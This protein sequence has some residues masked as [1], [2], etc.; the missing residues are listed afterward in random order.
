MN[1][2]EIKNCEQRRNEPN[3]SGCVK[4]SLSKSNHAILIAQLGTPEAPTAKAV[5]PYLREFL[6]DPRVIEANRILWWFVLNCIVLVTR[7]KRSARLY[8][9]IWTENGS[10]LL[11]L[12]KNFT[13]KL[14]KRLGRFNTQVVY[15]MRYGKPSIKSALDQLEKSGCKSITLVPMYPQ[16][17]ATT[18]ASTYDAFFAEVLKRRWVPTVSVVPP[19]FD[20][21]EFIKAQ[22]AIINNGLRSL[23][24]PTERLVLSY[25]GIPRRYIV[26][27]DPYCCMCTATTERLLP[28]LEIEPHKVIHTYQSRFGREPW[29]EPY[30][31]QTIEKLAREGIK[32]IAVA[33]PGFTT[34]CLET[35]DEIGNEGKHQ[36][37]EAGGEELQLIPCLNDSDVWVEA[38]ERILIQDG[39]VKSNDL[40]EK[41]TSVA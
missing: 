40:P 16:Y 9:R 28:L 27:G 11:L 35:L 37:I 21:P 29:L 30:T 2:I 36:F 41:L 39:F 13:A 34:D 12:T 23:S 6:S 10:P 19:Y 8:K 1:I 24:K 38:L 20:H 3:W 31:D 32:S 26:A 25:H 4:S 15:A 33:C 17:S 5:R 18:T 14:A 22:A 7:P